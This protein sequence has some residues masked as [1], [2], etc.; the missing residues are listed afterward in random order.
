MATGSGSTY[1]A[2]SRQT[3]QG[4]SAPLSPPRSTNCASARTSRALTPSVD[5]SKSPINFSLSP[6]LAKDLIRALI[7]KL[8]FIGPGAS[9]FSPLNLFCGTAIQPLPLIIRPVAQRLYI[10]QREF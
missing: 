6:L 8:K 2:N 7:D 9:D 10:F 5:L 3:T 1:L 4:W